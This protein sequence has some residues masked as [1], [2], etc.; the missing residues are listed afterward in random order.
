MPPPTIFPNV[1]GKRLLTNID[2]RVRPEKSL[3][4]P[5]RVVTASRT[6]GLFFNNNP[7]G[8]KYILATLCSNP[9]ATN[10][11][12]GKSMDSI[13]SVV[14]RPLIHNHTAR[15]T[16]ALHKTPR[17]KATRNDKP[18]LALAIKS[19]FAPT[20][21]LLAIQCRLRYIQSAIETAPIKFPK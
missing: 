19:A 11:V 4:L 15:Q 1:T 5:V 17:E 9:R 16:R 14:L 2:S 18:T 3:A 20:R 12:M 13:L 6:I 7:I 21:E 8:M 10:A